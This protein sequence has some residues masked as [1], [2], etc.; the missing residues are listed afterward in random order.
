MTT[1]PSPG[2][3]RWRRPALLV[4]ALLAL[5]AALAWALRPSPLVVELATVQRG[6]WTQTLE[7]DGVLRLNHRYTL[8]AP[9]TGDL[10]RPLLKVGDSVRS[11][12]VV[13]VLAPLAPAMIDARTREVLR[14]R[15]ASAQAA[16]AASQAQLARLQTAL[17]Q[18]ELDAE[19]TQALAKDNFVS[20]SALDQAAL[21]RQAAAQALR[22]GQAE[23]QAADAG[24]AEARAALA[25]AEPQGAASEGL[26]SLRSPV[27]GQVIALHKES[28]GPVTAGQPLLDLGNTDDIEATVDVLSTDV[29]RIPLAAPV[30]L[31]L[32]V[33]QP[34][35][36]GRVARIEP[37]AF[38]KVSALGI[39]EQRVLVHVALDRPLP[40][41]LRLG[42]G[43]R[44]DAR[45]TINQLPDALLVPTA[46]LLRAGETW[47]VAVMDASGRARLRE[48]VLAQRGPDLSVVER[49]LNAGEQVVRYP[50]NGIG[51]G[52]RLRA[53]SAP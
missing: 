31:S 44:V 6:P 9:T 13:A 17:R 16:R 29:G 48:V 34:P 33:Q 2:A 8:A 1:E 43:F 20:G 22:A 32:G 51:E 39:E 4:V 38:T 15:V 36:A 41:D 40:A 21:T 7:E 12:E 3:K 26:W 11:G 10:Q 47:R 28:G 23:A 14:Q 30:Q 52:Q 35:I 42:E 25:R 53:R 50:G 19:R 45:I 24:L 27:D 37:V 18:A 46:A 49:G 5:A